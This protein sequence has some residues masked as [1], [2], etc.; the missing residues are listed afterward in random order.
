MA[1]FVAAGYNHAVAVTVTGQ[2]W[3][4]GQ[5]T[6]GQIGLGDVQAAQVH[7]HLPG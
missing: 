6:Q 1:A 7:S 4:W 2:V 5:N 3:A